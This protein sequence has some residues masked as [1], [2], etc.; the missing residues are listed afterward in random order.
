MRSCPIVAMTDVLEPDGVV[1]T[2]VAPVGPLGGP[3]EP[4]PP[5]G[6]GGRRA[7]LGRRVD[8]S[9][10]VPGLVV[11]YGRPRG[12]K[13]LGEIVRLNPKKA[14]IRQLEARGVNPVGTEWRVPY[15][16]I[17]HYIGEVPPRGSVPR[18]VPTPTPRKPTRTPQS[19]QRW[20]TAGGKDLQAIL[21]RERARAV[22]RTSKALAQIDRAT[23]KWGK[24]PTGRGRKSIR[25][26][27]VKPSTGQINICP[28]LDRPDVP[29]YVVEAI[30]YHELLHL[31]IGTRFKQVWSSRY[32]QYRS[33]RVVHGPDFRRL[34][35][36]HPKYRES[37]A[38]VKA[39]LGCLLGRD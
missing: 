11:K 26:G 3:V 36:Q 20:A 19:A 23:I 10:L 37:E 1:S 33:Q 24:M 25:L 2:I 8:K 29:E 21:E 39:N 4:P 35:R 34:E 7:G 5:S 15:S 28:L 12:A 27:S 13:T 6:P 14:V 18:V 17:S 22:F 31:H 16:M 30:V 9:E 32:R 38:W